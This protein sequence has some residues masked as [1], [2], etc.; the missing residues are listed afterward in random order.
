MAIYNLENTV[1][2][3][4]RYRVFLD[5]EQVHQVI[6]ADTANGIITKYVEPLTV[7]DDELVTETLHGKVRVERIWR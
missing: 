5:G 4:R 6:E 1:L 7:R 3:G 2:I